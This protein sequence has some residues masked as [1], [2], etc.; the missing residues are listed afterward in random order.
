M[1]VV[2]LLLH[3][4]DIKIKIKSVD[5]SLIEPYVIDW[6]QSTTSLTRSSIDYKVIYY[7]YRHS[8]FLLLFFFFFLSSSSLK[9]V[10]FIVAVFSLNFYLKKKSGYAIINADEF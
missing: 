9:R 4:R 7:S 3:G 8:S 5:L 2:C 10:F 6:A 1:G